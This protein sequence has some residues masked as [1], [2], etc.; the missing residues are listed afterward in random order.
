[1]A[2]W[3]FVGVTTEIDAGRP[4]SLLIDGY[5]EFSSRAQQMHLADP[6]P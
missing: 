5:R 3:I 2:F 6:Q 4:T 1:M